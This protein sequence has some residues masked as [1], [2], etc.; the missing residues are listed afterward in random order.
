[1]TAS[2]EYSRRFLALGD[3]YTIGEGVALHERWPAQLARRLEARG[4]S[5]DQPV[6][7]AQTGW[8]TDELAAAMDAVTFAPPY[9]LVT[10]LIGVNDQ[11]R[12]RDVA[13]YRGAFAG[14]LERAITL[15]GGHANRVVVVSIPDWGVTGFAHA[16]ARDPTQ[17]ATAINA[18]NASAA[19]IAGTL[20]AAFVD[21]T[22]VSRDAGDDQAMLVGDRLHPTAAQYALWTQSILPAA[23]DALAS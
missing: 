2:A 4:I 18:F 23:A 1:M 8:T 12:G 19:H 21:I 3:S 10:L 16:Q 17:I 14:L 13:G 5:I 22:G 7:I 15:A 9:A 6:V 20:G 11:Y